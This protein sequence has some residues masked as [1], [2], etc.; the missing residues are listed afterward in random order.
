MSVL[1]EPEGL[2]K[3]VDAAG[4]SGTSQCMTEGDWDIPL[5]AAQEDITTHNMVGHGSI[6][7]D[8]A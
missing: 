1:K 3:D 5:P 4:P 8:S 2:A 7:F 6:T